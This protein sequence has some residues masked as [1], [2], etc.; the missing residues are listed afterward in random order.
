M[1]SP[2]ESGGI[3]GLAQMTSHLRRRRARGWLAAAM[4]LAGYGWL[5]TPPSQ[6]G[7]SHYASTKT[8]AARSQTVALDRLFAPVT[9]PGHDWRTS[10]LDE[11]PARPCSGF[12]CSRGSI[13]PL[14][15]PQDVPRIDAWGCTLLP[16]NVLR[17]TSS[18][19]PHEDG[20]PHSLDRVE[21]LARP[22]R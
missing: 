2:L 9:A 22:P 10:P 6:A 5:S 12:R 18:P 3:Y 21:R 13:P 20:S 1:H 11:H 15:V 4:L 8:D 14:G 7:C 16:A 19:F 17:P